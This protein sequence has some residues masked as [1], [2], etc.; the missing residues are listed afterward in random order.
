MSLVL[1]A[2]DKIPMSLIDDAQYWLGTIIHQNIKIWINRLEGE[3]IA[4]S[5][6]PIK[7]YNE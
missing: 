4:I 6:L 7:T 2:E 5:N 3:F 1:R